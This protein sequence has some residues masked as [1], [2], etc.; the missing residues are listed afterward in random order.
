MIVDISD[1][2]V[3]LTDPDDCGRF[4]VRVPP[5]MPVETVDAVLAGADAGQRSG[6]DQVAVDISW[7]RSSAHDVAPDWADR[8]EKM[9]AFAGTKG[10]LT[11]DGAAVLGHIVRD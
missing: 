6:P 9:L 7:L 2:A 3:A 8:F 4:H 5:D 10:W 1:T 11:D